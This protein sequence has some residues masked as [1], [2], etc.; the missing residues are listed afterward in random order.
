MADKDGP[1]VS[2]PPTGPDL[3]PPYE[4]SKRVARQVEQAFTYHPPYGNQA[5][6]YAQIRDRAFA[7][8]HHIAGHTPPSREQS[9]ALTKLEE[10]VMWA[11]AA[12]ARHENGQ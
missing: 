8:A 5:E 9:L 4:V 6:R 3:A 1:I 10:C 12:I 2:P 11:N 7:L